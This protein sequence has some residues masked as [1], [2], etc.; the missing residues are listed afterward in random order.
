MHFILLIAVTMGALSRANISWQKHKDSFKQQLGLSTT[1]IIIL[2]AIVTIACSV[3]FWDLGQ[4][5][6]NNDE[7]VYSGQAPR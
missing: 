1:E 7:A 4:I 3:R 6:F 5:G 2:I